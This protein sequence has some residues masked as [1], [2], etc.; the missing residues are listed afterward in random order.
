MYRIPNY[1]VQLVKESIVHSELHTV[2]NPNDAAELFNT[3]FPNCDRERL[4]VIMLNTRNKCVGVNTVSIGDL[5]SSIVHPREVFKP[6]ILANACSIIIMHNHPS[7]DPSPSADDIN[8]TKRIQA[9]S[10]LIGIE[11]IDHVIIG[12]SS[13]VSLKER[14]LV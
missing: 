4:I 10:E 13:H 2:S 12:D 3:A 5:T 11:L 9:C 7:G 1:S 6:A 14:G 8:I